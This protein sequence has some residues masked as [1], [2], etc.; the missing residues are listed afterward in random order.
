MSD[1]SSS[2]YDAQ[3]QHQPPEGKTADASSAANASEQKEVASPIEAAIASIQEILTELAKHQ[4]EADNADKHHDEVDAQQDEKINKLS[5]EFKASKK[6]NRRAVMAAI[7]LAILYKTGDALWENVVGSV[8]EGF[9]TFNAEGVVVLED[10]K[11]GRCSFA[12]KGTK[13]PYDLT[14]TNSLAQAQHAMDGQKHGHCFDAGGSIGN[15]IAATADGFE[16]ATAAAQPDVHASF[17]N[18]AKSTLWKSLSA[19]MRTG[20]KAPCWPQPTTL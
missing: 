19:L 18:K 5:K 8:Y 20:L 3:D 4:K 13:T 10:Y 15:L 12:G 1:D 2:T 16:F 6:F 14:I 17:K 7:G 11:T 9:V